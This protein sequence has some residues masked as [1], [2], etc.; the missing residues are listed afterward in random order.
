MKSKC[1]KRGFTII[2]L[3][4]VMSIIIVLVAILV[5]SLNAINRYARM[6]TQKGQFHD[7]SKCLEMFSVTFKEGYPDSSAEDSGGDNYCGAM[8][9]CEAMLGQD[10]LGYHP[11]SVFDDMGLDAFGT[12]LYFNRSNTPPDLGDDDDLA[13]IRA[14]QQPC[15]EGA[16]AQLV[17]VETLFPGNGLYDGNCPLLSDVYKRSDL[18]TSS[19]EKCGM[20]VLYFKADPSK[21]TNDA[22][23]IG[24]YALS[25][26]NIYNYWDNDEL[27]SIGLNMTA[28]PMYDSTAA[29]NNGGALFYSK[30][31]DKAVTVT[32]KPRNANTYILISAGWDGLYG[33]RDDV[34]NFE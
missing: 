13:N 14:R 11:D 29:A 20:P 12:D 24:D 22:N 9:L 7:I 3:L 15:L 6:V 25:G 27:L 17:S 2:E 31:K 33:T 10:G 19:G 32:E 1:K 34:F 23:E 30:I 18:R 26:K 8:K 5:P 28:H 21:L 4:T 16:Y